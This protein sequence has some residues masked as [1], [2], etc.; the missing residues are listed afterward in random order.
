MATKKTATKKTAAK[1]KATGAKKVAAK[2]KAA[3]KKAAGAKKVAAKK[4]AS[5]R[6]N[7]SN[8]TDV[9]STRSASNAT[10]SEDSATHQTAGDGVA[11]LTTAQGIAVADDQNSLT[12]GERGPVLLEDFQLREKI[13]HFDHERI[14]ERV[15]H[16]RGY[17]A[18]GY[19]ENY[20]DQSSLTAASLFG[21]AGER[22]EVFCRFSTVAGSAGS[23]DLARDTR[24]FAVKFY[25]DAGNWDLVGNNIPVFFIQDAIKFPD[26]IHSVKPEPHTGFPQAQSAHDNFW[27]FVSLMPEAM[28]HLMWVM[29]DRGIP[30][31]FRMMEGFGVHTF[32]FVTPTVSPRT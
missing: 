12:V 5:V 29:S 22:T 20:E 32:R 24:G 25:T 30:R 23:P 21:K 4:A 9:G 31:S 2:K 17:G 1:K 13:F 10:P 6:A 14:P 27:D 28:H 26:L 16:A 19:F 8:R 11:T 3:S 18:R 7:S 15:V